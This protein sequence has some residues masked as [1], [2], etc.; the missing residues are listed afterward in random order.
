MLKIPNVK[1]PM[2]PKPFFRLVTLFFIVSLTFFS[3]ANNIRFSVGL[4]QQENENVSTDDSALDMVL[5]NNK[6]NVLK[7]YGLPHTAPSFS[8]F[9]YSFKVLTNAEFN[10]QKP[11][12]ALPFDVGFVAADGTIN[13]S[14]PT[15]EAQK[16]VFKDINKAAVYYL[17]QSYMYFFYQT[18]GL[19]LLFKVGFP[20]YEA[21]LDP[22]DTTIKE[23][24]NKYGGSFSSFDLL[25]NSTTFVANSGWTI[26]C[27]FGEFMNIYKN[28]GYPMII[29]VTASSFDA[30]PGW[31]MTDNLKGL[32][33]DYNRYIYA[34]FLE[35]DETLRIKLIKETEH[36]R[37]YTRQREA[38]VN[39]P[40]LPNSLENAYVEF[41]TNYNTK[42]YGKLSV[43]TLSGCADPAIEAIPCDPNSTVLGG[44]AWSSG[45]HFGCYSTADQ[46]KDVN[47]MGRH[48]LA[49][50]FQGFMPIGEITQWLGEGF[51]FFSDAGPFNAD[52][53]NM[54]MEPGF[55]KHMLI[56]S[57][58][59]GTTFFGHRPTYEDTKIYPGY[60][61]D[62]G[63]K[64]LGWYLNDFIYRKGG[65]TAVKDV[66]LGDL[67]GYKK[68]GY[69]SGQAFM[70]DFY[71][72]F[73]VRVQ[74]I[75]MLTLKTP[76][77]D[78]ELSS[79]PVG[80]SWTPLKADVKLNVL[81]SIDNKT[82]WTEVASKTTQTSSTW[83]AGTYTGKFF[84]KFMAPDNL[85]LET[86]FGPFYLIDPT[87][88]SLKV[89]NGGEY[90][91][92]GDT[93]RVQWD[94]TIIPKIKLEYSE[95]NGTSWNT[96]ETNITGSASFYK[97][98]VP[99]KAAS[100]YKVRIS[101]ASNAAKS[102]LS[103]N[104]FTVLESNS[105]CGPYVYDKNTLLLLHFDNDLANRAYAS[106]DATGTVDN[107][108][109]DATRTAA[110]G[111]TL[112]TPAPVSVKHTPNLNLSGDWTIEAWVKLT[113]A[114]TANNMYILTKPGDSDAYAANYSLEIN[115]WWGNVFHG[116]YF[117]GAGA[118]IGKSLQTVRPGEWYHVA[119]IRDTK[120]SEIRMIIR[121]KN[122]TKIA[123]DFLKYT[124]N[125]TYVNSK[126]LLIGSGLDGYIDELRIS[127]VVRSFITLDAEKGMAYQ[128]VNVY[129]NPTSGRLVIE[130]GYIQQE[131]SVTLIDA[132]GKTVSQYNK[133]SGSVNTLDISS[134]S[135]GMY[136]LQFVNDKTV[137]LKKIILN[138]Q[139]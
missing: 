70:D 44:T 61:T 34:R 139:K 21:G 28:W 38:D 72:D 60:E 130:S 89:P 40:Y 116:F 120:N 118:R 94:T 126:D 103:E 53:S 123:E 127:N 52:Y 102:D 35:A 119:Y 16:T 92:A 63:Y 22:T 65:Y 76:V 10:A 39:F 47:S 55:W 59:R 137:S 24:I 133:L 8:N 58:E 7:V 11:T 110:F 82:S 30:A 87:T 97:W 66:Q 27:A 138:N 96:I 134:F 48:E 121:D 75:P 84:L 80:I 62:Y 73:D 95:N 46:L 36:F 109:S 69:S 85:N 77:V 18:K 131:F 81:V 12:D 37:I 56:S 51:A 100:Q 15:T 106:G 31:F 125:T 68:M 117:S 135:P 124:V 107:L 99:A 113:S 14:A 19:P 83:N 90:L 98:L 13:V 41:S 105:I 79:P 91:V 49:H 3:S 45:T 20:A 108:Q 88:V 50:A 5:I 74:N 1:C 112:R 136:Y 23:A 101:D 17:C 129:P 25:N 67:A 2:K 64:Y 42:A 33:D 78:R 114:N 29:N 122:R 86:V 111:N 32:L 9:K 93:T 132:A 26:A 54:N 104:V 43:F 57:L 115:P 4:N 6:I 128:Q 71:Y